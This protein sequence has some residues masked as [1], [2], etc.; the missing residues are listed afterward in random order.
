MGYTVR[1]QEEAQMSW[2]A[3]MALVI[4]ALTGGFYLGVRKSSSASAAT[5]AATESKVQ[6]IATQVK[7]EV[8]AKNQVAQQAATAQ[9]K[10]DQSDANVKRLTAKLRAQGTHS[11]SL[12]PGTVIPSNNP[13]PEPVDT[14]KDELIAAQAQD[15]DNFKAVNLKLTLEITT[16]NGIIADQQ[17]ELDLRKIEVDASEAANKSAH[18]KGIFQGGGTVAI[19]W[20]VV[21][22]LAHF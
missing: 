1:E 8:E 11:G 15:I 5:I 21:H 22:L 19:A 14:T 2:K 13:D 7:N 3:W 6:Q 16:D 20:G 18:V 12:T 9:A 17:K 10:A 4:L